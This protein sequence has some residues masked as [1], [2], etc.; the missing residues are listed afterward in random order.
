MHHTHRAR[1]DFGF[2][3]R[4]G[5]CGPCAYS[6]CHHVPLFKEFICSKIGAPEMI[7][8]EGSYKIV[9]IQ[10]RTTG[11]LTF[12][13]KSVLPKFPNHGRSSIA[14]V[15]QRLSGNEESLIR[16]S[17]VQGDFQPDLAIYCQNNFKWKKV[18]PC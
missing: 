4:H 17:S 18:L 6:G 8:K 12:W 5:Q 14:E 1:N 7:R 15:T 2:Y 13:L 16:I 9:H 11:A 10:E 3:G